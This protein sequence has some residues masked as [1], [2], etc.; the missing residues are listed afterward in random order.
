MN[1]NP[2][3]VGCRQRESMEWHAA[4]SLPGSDVRPEN[5]APHPAKRMVS[6]ERGVPSSENG[7]M[8]HMD[9]QKAF[10]L[11]SRSEQDSGLDEV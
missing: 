8:N 5:P 9:I 3:G 4:D 2:L 10:Q 1:E 6:E 11:G 7:A